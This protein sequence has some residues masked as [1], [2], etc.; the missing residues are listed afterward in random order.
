[1]YTKLQNLK[2]NIKI[3]KTLKQLITIEEESLFIYCKFN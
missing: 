1:M 2:S 3:S